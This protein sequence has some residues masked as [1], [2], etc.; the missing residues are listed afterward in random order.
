MRALVIGAS[1]ILSV[2]AVASADPL[3]GSSLPQNTHWVTHF[4]VDGVREAK[5]LWEPL[6][7]KLLVQRHPE[8]VMRIAAFEGITGM[9]LPDD[10]HDVT[11]YG[12][13]FDEATACIRIHGKLDTASVTGVIAQSKDFLRGDHNG[14]EVLQWHD[15]S[16]DRLTYIAF[17]M[18][19]FAVLAP[20]RK[21][22]EAALDLSDGK[23]PA[24]TADS[25][26]NPPAGSAAKPAPCV[27]VAA[28]GLSGLPSNKVESPLLRVMDSAA[29]AVRWNNDRLSME[30]RVQTKDAAAAQQLQAVAEGIKAFVTLTAEGEHPAPRMRLLA[31][32]LAPMKFQ[33]EGRV[34][35]GEWTID[36]DKIDQLINATVLES[37]APGTTSK[38]RP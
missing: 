29:F 33:A 36:K 32:T 9:K 14:H 22:I 20:S 4:D 31:E 34:L 10:L 35:K 15:N 11:L 38:P 18:E 7:P 27:W 25:A 3:A 37:V 30:T 28:D 12:S 8:I 26:L 13:D 1:L 21:T 16:R 19:N 24:L 17:P 2:V 23:A 6:H 5:P